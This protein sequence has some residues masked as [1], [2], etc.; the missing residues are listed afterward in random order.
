MDDL[1]FTCELCDGELEPLGTLGNT[2]HSKCRDCGAPQARTL[3]EA[4]E[5][6]TDEA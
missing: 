2:V 6:D 1:G 5:L 3:V 4:P